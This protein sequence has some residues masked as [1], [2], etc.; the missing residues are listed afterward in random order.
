[1]LIVLL[2]LSINHQIVKIYDRS[3]EV[4][5]EWVKRL[6]G[7]ARLGPLAGAVNAP[8]NDVF[9]TH[10]VDAETLRMQ[11]ALR[12]FG[13]HMAASEQDLREKIV[14]EEI[15]RLPAVSA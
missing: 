12:A 1:M 13:E 15:E 3:V 10:D 9:D 11:S 4:N 14:E 7:Y 6:N 5:Q 8:G 2:G